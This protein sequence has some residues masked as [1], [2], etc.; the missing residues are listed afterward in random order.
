MSRKRILLLGAGGTLGSY[1]ALELLNLDCMVD[2]VALEKLIS[3]HQNLTCIQS[4]VTD[5]LLR[6]LFARQRY[7]GIVDFIHYADPEA[8]KP[9]ARLLLENTDHLIFLSSYRVY[10]G[11]ETPIVETSPQLLDTVQDEYFQ[12]HEDYAVPK[13]KNERF[14]RSLPQKNWTIVRPLISFSHFRLD[15]VTT[16]MHHLL[17]AAEMKQRL[18]LPQG[19]RHLAAGVG[20]AGN[21]GKM[22]ARLVLNPAACGEDYTLG[23]AEELTWQDVA[24]C[25]T[26]LLG[27]EFVWVDDQVYLEQATPNTYANHCM[28]YHD[29]LLNRRIDNR[30]VLAATGLTQTDL[31][32]L[33]EAL[34]YELSVIAQRPDRWQRA[35][36]NGR[37]GVEKIN[38]WLQ[39][40]QA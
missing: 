20:W 24:D 3:F 18:M 30:K 22:L 40:H 32:P 36:E 17:A 14:L 5:E 27:I 34:I 19:A 26:D 10:A 21:V 12:T 38:A 13:A 29:R 25:Y 8:Y 1:T 15:L 11:C 9:R 16:G 6:D 33:R 4:P 28:L 39:E 37:P 2:V 31:L 23:S 35:V 7:D